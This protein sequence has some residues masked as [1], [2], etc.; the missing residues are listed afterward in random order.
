ERAEDCGPCKPGE[1][2]APPR[3]QDGCHGDHEDR[4]R[5][6]QPDQVSDGI[7]ELAAVV[8]QIAEQAEEA[9]R[10]CQSYCA[11]EQNPA[12]LISALFKATHRLATT[13]LVGGRS[14][15][16]FSRPPAARPQSHG[17]RLPN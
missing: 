16:D 7:S 8:E 10:S 15:L 5:Q 14:L 4:E 3:L 2:S 12:P 9:L 11:V 17:S 13:A 6:G 1:H